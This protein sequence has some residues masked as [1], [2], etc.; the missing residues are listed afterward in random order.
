MAKEPVLIVDDNPTNLKLARVIL[1]A[2]GYQIRVATDGNEALGVLKSFRPALILMDIQ[3]PGIDGLEL[4]RRL[5]ADPET[6]DIRIIAVTAYAMK[7][8][9]EKAIAAGCDGYLTK[10][11]DPMTLAGVVASHIQIADRP[12]PPLGPQRPTPSATI[13]VV[14]DN[15]ITRKMIRVALEAHAY[16]VAE[17]SDGA[18]AMARIAKSPPALVLQ[19][20]VLP[21]ID[22]LELVVR[23]RETLGLG[24]P[25]LC[26]TGFL[27]RLDEIQA[28]KGGF[29][30]VLLKPVDPIDLIDSVRTHLG[31]GPSRAAAFESGHQVL[32]VDDDPLQR[33]LA[34]FYLTNAG[35]RVHLA[36][37]GASALQEAAKIR[38]EVIV[39][40][41]LM[42]TMDGFQ[43]ALLARGVPALAHVPI[44]LVSSHYI[45]DADRKLALKVGARVL[46]QRTP[47]WDGVIDAVNEA[48][49]ARS[50]GPQPELGE[51]DTG[52]HSRRILWQLERQATQNANL[53]RRC[54]IQAAQLAVLAGTAE[55]LAKNQRLNG[56]LGDVLAACLDMAGISKGALYLANAKGQLV[57][58][59]RIGFAD[60]D[61][62][63]L[64][65]CF[66][67]DRLIRRIIDGGNVTAV[68]SASIAGDAA[69]QL[70]MQLGVP[71]ALI[72]PVVWASEVHG[73]LLLG[74]RTADMSGDESIAFA[75]VLGLQMAQAI[76]LAQTFNRLT[77]AEQR[78]R[79]L[80]ESA[81]DAVCVMTPDGI[82]V[83]VNRKWEELLRLKREQIVGRPLTDFAV[84]ERDDVGDAHAP[85]AISGGSPR[86]QA[87]RVQNPD[88]S[89]ALLEMSKVSL[90][91]SGERVVFAIGRDVTEQ[92]REQAQLMTSDRMASVG[93]LASGVAHE[94]NNPLAAVL[95]NLEIAAT[96]IEKLVRQGVASND[97]YEE[98]KD[99]REAADRV[100]Q[101]ARDRKS[102]V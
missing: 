74:A 44:V 29:S 89:V 6:R 70:L 63:R 45:E 50:P 79:T 64:Q 9:E 24:V 80:M 61:L 98:I 47:E 3:L 75:R 90:E 86:T 5:K 87:V 94:I 72:V 65:G 27:S 99:A 76:G 16:T 84:V 33:K 31:H 88:G 97:L 32:V 43:F 62:E 28:V 40:D 58:R 18:S 34:Q 77:L 17:A 13:L 71:A 92:T 30:A 68:P 57:L 15:P 20:L 36:A 54:T 102:V 66:G 42:P 22:G 35:F 60:T 48:L 81:H 73:A 1:E 10:P 12:A 78:Y 37:D 21:D 69:Q 39:S 96:E 93:L 53:A 8:D 95:A 83:E 67:Q 14:E 101:V 25:I 82:V 41:V 46:V 85:A 100:R 26:L 56:V 4:T 91:I 49:R 7:G 38:A 59:E 23:L 2:E 51:L 19:D 52:E 55:A 11:L